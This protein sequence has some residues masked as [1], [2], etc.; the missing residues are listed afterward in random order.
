MEGVVEWDGSETARSVRSSLLFEGELPGKIAW[1][2]CV[3]ERALKGVS[4]AVCLRER[5]LTEEKNRG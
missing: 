2:N 5:V 3:L 1:R 4:A